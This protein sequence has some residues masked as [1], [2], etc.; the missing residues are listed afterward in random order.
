LIVVIAIVGVL[1]AGVAP[2]MLRDALP[3]DPLA[4]AADS[5]ALLMDRA[6]RAAVERAAPV[7]LVIDPATGRWWARGAGIDTTG[8]LAL[9]RG[10]G[11]VV[12]GPAGARLQARFD[13]RGVATADRV[14]LRAGGRLRAV[15]A[16]RW[17]GVSVGANDAR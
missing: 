9:D 17:T 3:R 10:V 5:V 7:R 4:V 16:E 14:V 8:V 6:R 12:E 1:A 13:P 11:I 15:T 2:A